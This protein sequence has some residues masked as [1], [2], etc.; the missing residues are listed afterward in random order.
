MKRPA[1]Y[2]VFIAL[3]ISVYSCKKDKETEATYPNYSQFKAGSYWVYQRFNI[4]SSGN[5]E[6]TNLYDSCYVVKDTIINNQT[7]VKTCRTLPYLPMAARYTYTRDSLHY[8]L[9]SNGFLLFSSRD[10][11]TPLA[12]Q[13][14]ITSS[15]DTV[16]HVVKKMT[17]KDLLVV[18][19]AGTFKTSDALETYTLYP[20]LNDVL[21]PR[22][23]HNRY[24][25]N[26][27]IVVETIPF[28]TSDP[29][30]VERRLVRYHVVL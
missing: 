8:V 27:G 12:D 15:N 11:E 25:E 19:P 4:D 16:F 22:Y 23:K 26:I 1:G 9:S 30:T 24:A 18:T 17:D 21:S 2:L 14:S 28:Y 29:N 5:E 7:Y 10:Y 6:A 20:L 3:A 13:Y